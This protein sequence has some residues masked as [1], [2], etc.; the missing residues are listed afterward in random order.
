MN[1]PSLRQRL[2]AILLI[3]VSC[4]G[5]LAAFSNYY[6]TRSRISQLLDDQLRQFAHTILDFSGHE[7]LEQHG[8]FADLDNTLNDSEHSEL[9]GSQYSNKIA[10]QVWTSDN[11]LISRS[12]NAPLHP[13][14][15]HHTGL[16]DITLN[17]AQWRVF[18][19]QDSSHTLLIYAA[20]RSD[21][22]E[23]LIDAITLNLGTS[24]LFSLPLFALAIWLGVRHALRPLNNI[25]EE[26]SARA[27]NAL[28]AIATRTIPI[29]V[30]PLI[31]SMNQLLARVD[32]AIENER[33][34]T[35][36]AAHELRTPLAALKT[37]AQVALRAHDGQDRQHALESVVAGVDRASHMINQLLTLSRLDP[38]ADLIDQGH[39]D[40]NKIATEVLIQL[41][42]KAHKKNIELSL[43]NTAELIV[44]GNGDALTILCRNL[45]DNAI[46]YTPSGGKVQ[47]NYY[48]NAL[49]QTELHVED[50]GPG[51]PEEEMGRITERF[52]RRSNNM[53]EGVGLGLSI[54]RRIAELHRAKLDFGRAPLGGLRAS[55]YFPGAATATVST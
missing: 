7:L 16:L 55:V 3:T 17:G 29:E 14:A 22:R 47:V 23:Q 9:S 41:H 13:L 35:A 45:V 18:A 10:Y 51:I 6:E 43:E 19:L 42:D 37:L 28:H 52:Y 12:H 49:G 25:T 20:E 50:S 33:R 38:A 2:L 40:L 26:I 31:E 8:M 46:R 34:F 24:A 53:E 21:V 5:L 48:K 44:A 39:P 15:R 4:A 30:R 36:D 32:I 11:E 27:P 54:V 1:T